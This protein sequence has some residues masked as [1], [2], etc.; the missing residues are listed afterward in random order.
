MPSREVM[1]NISKSVMIPLVF[2]ADTGGKYGLAF[3]QSSIFE[4]TGNHGTIC[5]RRQID[6]LGFALITKI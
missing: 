6:F 4:K 2:F 3:D 1:E 5:A